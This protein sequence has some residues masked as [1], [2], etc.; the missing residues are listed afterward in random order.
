[1]ELC[2]IPTSTSS[3][4]PRRLLP[5]VPEWSGVETPSSSSFV[6]LTGNA[7]A[8]MRHRFRSHHL[9]IINE[10]RPLLWLAVFV[11]E[12]RTHIIPRAISPL[13]KVLQSAPLI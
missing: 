3:Q 12:E 9:V 11:E 2:Q 5:H 4:H 10:K 7:A 8:P 6:H 13:Q 1:M